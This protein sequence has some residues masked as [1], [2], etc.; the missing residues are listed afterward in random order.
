[1]CVGVPVAEVVEPFGPGCP[2][3]SSQLATPGG[4][5]SLGVGL[6]GP[7]VDVEDRRGGM[8]VDVPVAGHLVQVVR[9]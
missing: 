6:A 1:M 7:V 8:C 9:G 4:V 5:N 2:R 3:L